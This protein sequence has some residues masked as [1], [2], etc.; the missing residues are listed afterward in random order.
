MGSSPDG[1]MK[2]NFG[3]VHLASQIRLQRR[4]TV[5]SRTA[6]RLQSRFK[7]ISSCLLLCRMDRRTAGGD[8][9]TAA[10][11]M[12]I[13]SAVPAVTTSLAVSV[14][15]RAD[16]R[17][18]GAEHPGCTAAS[19]AAAWSVH[20]HTHTHA[21]TQKLKSVAHILSKKT[22]NLVYSE[23]DFQIITTF[24]IRDVATDQRVCCNCRGDIG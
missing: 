17:C 4:L 15:T 16:A 22:V 8:P 9:V 23:E 11:Q 6:L 3:K 5:N 13:C 24:L 19:S 20:T 14:W 10:T 18:T 7:S 12:K 1:H 2:K 21:F